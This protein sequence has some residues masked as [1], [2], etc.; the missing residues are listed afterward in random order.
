VDKIICC[1]IPRFTAE[2]FFIFA[3]N[4]CCFV[5]HVGKQQKCVFTY[6]KETSSYF[7]SLLQF[8]LIFFIYCTH[9]THAAIIQEV[10]PIG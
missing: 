5:A 3:A 9:L 8:F 2:V 1:C 6:M 7:C 4:T 10:V